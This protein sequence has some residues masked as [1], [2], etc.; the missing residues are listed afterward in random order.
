MIKKNYL[1]VMLSLCLMISTI[2]AGCSTSTDNASS[3]VASSGEMVKSETDSSDKSKQQESESELTESDSEKT[4][5]GDVAENG[6]T[7]EDAIALLEE[8]EIPEGETI[9]IG[10]LAMNESIQYCADV[11]TNLKE[12]AARFDGQVELTMFD[13]RGDAALQVSQAE[14]MVTLDVDAVIISVIDRDSCMPAIDGIMEADIPVIVLEGP[15]VENCTAKTGYDFIDTSVAQVD[16]IA[17]ALDGEGVINII[18]GQSGNPSSEYGVAGV[19][20]GIKKYPGLSIGASQPADWDRAKAMNITEDW[21]ISGKNFD[22]I[23]AL[24]DEMGVAAASACES[25]G[26]DVPIVGIDCQDETAELIREGVM[27][28]S[29]YKNPMYEGVSSMAL[30]IAAAT[31]IEIEDSYYVPYTAVTVENVDTYKENQ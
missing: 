4:A 23:I 3:S 25:A 12:T 31:G 14:D 20:E 29:I 10:Y 22:A 19:E 13:G 18:E 7:Y 2:L 15:D 17:E 6:A 26:V 21:I 16:M 27:Y 1:L 9:N 30:A 8:I 11:S 24:N 5:S 28:G